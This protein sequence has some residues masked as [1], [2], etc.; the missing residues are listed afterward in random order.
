MSEEQKKQPKKPSE[1]SK[2]VLVAKKDFRI[3]QNSYDR[4]IQAGQDISDVPEMYHTN[5]KT[6]GVL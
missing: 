5:L 4:V 3:T 1:D 6:E 2:P